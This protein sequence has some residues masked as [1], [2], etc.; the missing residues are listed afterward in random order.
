MEGRR[1]NGST[2]EVSN[3]LISQ[4]QFKIEDT[5]YLMEIKVRGIKEECTLCCF[6]FAYVITTV[7]KS[8]SFMITNQDH[9][10]EQLLHSGVQNT[11][12]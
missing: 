11:P 8:D 6:I 9:H 5:L 4:N 10:I 12:T 3:K 2:K 1:N 7:L